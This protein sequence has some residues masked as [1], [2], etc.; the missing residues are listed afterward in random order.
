VA[1]V[2]IRTLAAIRDHLPQQLTSRLCTSLVISRL[3][4]C[5]SVLWWV[6][7]YSLHPLQLALNMAA[8]LVFKARRSCHVSPL[9][10]AKVVADRKTHREKILTLV[11]KARNGLCPSYAADL[12]HVYVPART[13]RS[14]DTP[15]LAVPVGRNADAKP[16]T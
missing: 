3:D 15:T 7:K 12:L 9:R 4:C 14:T 13:L 2:Y 1:A 6:P 5:S 11:L 16:S 8:R 10:P